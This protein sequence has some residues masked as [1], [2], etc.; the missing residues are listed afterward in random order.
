MRNAQANIS[1]FCLVLFNL[2]VFG[3]IVTP[4]NCYQVIYASTNQKRCQ[5]ERARD[6][7]LLN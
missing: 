3:K 6:D 4:F 7:S 5:E 2:K 1:H